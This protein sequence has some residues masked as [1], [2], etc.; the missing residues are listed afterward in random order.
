MN[1]FSIIKKLHVF[2]LK[3]HNEVDFFMEKVAI[4][5]F[6]L[7]PNSDTRWYWGERVPVWPP[8]IFIVTKNVFP[9]WKENIRAAWSA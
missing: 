3:R 9:C 4:E 1:V 2:G 5:R 6:L 7:V 8:Q